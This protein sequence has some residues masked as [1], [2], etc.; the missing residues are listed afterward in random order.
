MARLARLGALFACLLTAA[1]AARPVEFRFRVPPA[2]GVRNPFAREIWAEVATPS[3]RDLLLPAFCEGGTDF[4]VRA[5]PSE[6]G[7]Y[8]LGKVVEATEGRKPAEIAAVPLSP[9]K[10]VNRERERLPAILVDPRHPRRFIRSDGAP[11][12][13]IGANVAW[14]PAGAAPGPYYRT[15]LAAFARAHLSWMRVWMAHWSGLSLD[16]LPPE[17]GRSPPPGGID[18][19]VAG[20]WD[21]IV[22]AADQDGVYLQIVFEYHGEYSTKTDSNW[23]E[24]PWNAA[25]PGGFLKRPEDFFTDPRARLFTLLK[26]RY[27]AARWGWSPAIFA[28]ELFNEVFWTDAYVHGDQAAI[29]RW[30]DQ[31]A[32]YLRQVD[33]Y[34]HLITTSERNLRSPIYARMD[35]YQPHV[36][37]ADILA[38]VRRFDPPAATLDKPVFYGEMGGEDL[39]ISRAEEAEGTALVPPMWASLMGEG[40]YPAQPWEGARLL[41]LHRLGEVEA[42]LRFVAFTPYLSHPGARPFSAAVAPSALAAVGRRD[43]SFIALWVWRRDCVFAAARPAPATGTI[44]LPDVPA[45][46]WRVTWWDSLTGRPRSSSTIDHPGG[47]LRL[48]TPAIARQAAVDLVRAAGPA[49]R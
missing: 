2:A 37:S 26:Y 18:P 39:P 4:A 42:V 29:A 6:L 15:A 25:N 1:R 30:H 19:R 33:V 21:Q 44:V 36:Y 45:G 7:T 34:P 5:R 40:G 28:W 41:A 47:T 14:P 12:F 11:Y 20:R 32:D 43:G 48:P 3:G 27:I 31:M 17:M 8:Q 16:W 24:N 23:S 38:A 9:R 22:E 49:S 13:P 35:F 10:V 46:R